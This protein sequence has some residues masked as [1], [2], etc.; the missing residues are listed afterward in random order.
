MPTLVGKGI[1]TYPTD[2]DLAEVAA[3]YL[4][5]AGGHRYAKG[6]NQIPTLTVQSGTYNKITGGLWGVVTNG[7]MENATSYLTLE[8]T[9]KVLGFVSGT[10]GKNS[11]Y[12]GHVN[13]TINGGT[14]ECDIFGCGNTGMTNTDGSVEITIN[15]GDF[16]NVWSVAS[17]APTMANNPPATKLLDLSGWTGDKA[18]LANLFS[19]SIDFDVVRLP[20]GV[21]E[22]ELIDIASKQTEAPAT[23]APETTKTP[24]TDKPKETAKETQKPAPETKKENDDNSTPVTPEKDNGMAT[25]LIAVI[26]IAVVII[27]GMGAVIIVLLKKNKKK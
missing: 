9:T 27:V 4:S 22:A 24:E 3:N 18:D 20:E 8:G 19:L 17:M 16:T 5:L 26:V 25:V 23:D 7:G 2:E 14:Y 12:S 15:G 10:V 6:T 11:T 21:T 13:I 1:K